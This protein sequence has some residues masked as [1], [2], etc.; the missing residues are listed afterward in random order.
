MAQ[1]LS[2]RDFIHRAKGVALAT[3]FISLVGCSDESARELLSLRGQTMGTTYSIKLV[4]LPSEVDQDTLAQELGGLLEAVNQDMSTYR[5]ESELSRFNAATA[6][7]W[8]A[9]SA[10]TRSVVNEALRIARL[11]GGAF[12]PTVG[13]LVDLW[14]FGAAGSEQRIPT[15]EYIAA[16]RETIGFAKVEIQNEPPQL[17]KRQDGVRLDLSG[18]AKGFAVDKLAAHLDAQGITDYLV[19]VGGELRARGHGPE[20]RPWRVGIEKP[21][22]APGELQRVVDLD[23]GGLATSGNYRIFFEQDGERYTHIVNPRSGRPVEHDLASATVVADSTMEA[24]ALSTSL[25]VLGP[26]AGMTLAVEHDIAALFVT[27]R[28]GAFNELASPAFERRFT[29]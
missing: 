1:R 29:A 4:N 28:S 11:T 2:R 17:A 10:D 5:P 6:E 8:Q 19:E 18:V 21:T 9:V 12:D 25:L 7:S 3:P 26:E 15:P 24:D 27:G 20:G 16:T 23:R 22:M 14:G 13:P